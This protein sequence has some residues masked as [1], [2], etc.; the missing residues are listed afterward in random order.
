M[1]GTYQYDVEIKSNVAELLSNMKQ[2]Q[3][4]L[5]TVEGR[6]YTVKLNIDE[7]KLSNVISNLEKMLNS[8][9]K[10]T[11]D[12]KQFEN[13]SK[14]LSTIMSEA[15]SLSKAFG[16]VDDSGTKTLLSSIHNIDKSLSDLS[17]NILNVNKNMSNMGGNTNNAV[18]QIENIT[19][20][21]KEA[22]SAINDIANAKSKI[23]DSNSNNILKA[24]QSYKK[25]AEDYNKVS[26]KSVEL[27]SKLSEK[28]N[29]TKTS[30]KY[31]NER[32]GN[33]LNKFY[34]DIDQDGKNFSKS[35]LNE[36][37]KTIPKTKKDIK[38][39][40][41][42]T[43]DHGTETD[44]KNL[45]KIMGGYFS[46]LDI[47][48]NI[49]EKKISYIKSFTED[50]FKQWEL[51]SAN[52]ESTK[53]KIKPIIKDLLNSLNIDAHDFDIDQLLTNGFLDRI[54]L[55]D[56]GKNPIKNVRKIFDKYNQ[57]I[58]N[59]FGLV[60]VSEINNVDEL[61]KKIGEMI[62]KRNKL[63]DNYVKSLYT[64]DGDHELQKEL[65]LLDEKIVAYSKLQSIVK[66]QRSQESNISSDNKT[67]L[68]AKKELK[69][70]AEGLNYT[71]EQFDKLNGLDEKLFDSIAKGE[72]S[73]REALNKIQV[74][75]QE[76]GN[77]A[78]STSDKISNIFVHFGTD[79]DNSKFEKI[80]NR[81]DGLNKP[82]K[83][84]WGSYLDSEYGWEQ[85]FEDPKKYLTSTYFESNDA[86]EWFAYNEPNKILQSFYKLKEDAHVLVLETVEDLQ[87]LPSRGLH[88]A[89]KAL[90]DWEKIAEQYDAISV[91]ISNSTNEFRQAMYGWDADSL[92][93][94]NPNAIIQVD[95]PD[96][97][98]KEIEIAKQIDLYKQL[99]KEAS[100]PMPIAIQLEDISL[101]NSYKNIVKSTEKELKLGTID[102]NT[103]LE[104]QQEILKGTVFYN[105]K[106]NKLNPTKD[107]F[108]DSSTNT[109]PEIEG[110]EQVEKATEEAVQAKKDFATANEGVQS[111]IDGSENP[112]KLE[113]EL[114]EQ[115]AKSARGAADA[116]KEFV[117]VNKQVKDS[118]NKSNNDLV[119]G[120]SEN[121][122][123]S[124]VK[125]YKKK[126]Y[127]AHDTGNHDNEKKV[128]NK[129][130]LG[131]VLKD[132]QSEIIASIDES[133]SF[134]KEV[135]DFYDSQDNLVKTQMKVG[136]K[137]GNMR[138]YT[139][140]YSMD[141]DDNATAWTSHIETQKFTDQSKEEL[142]V[143]KQITKELEDQEKANQ[144]KF[145]D[146]QKEN[147]DFEEE[148]KETEA[149]KRQKDAYESLMTTI[150]EYGEVYKSLAN[151]QGDS[152]DNLSKMS[153]LE[154]KISELQKKGILSESQIEKSE[155]ALTKIYNQVDKI[156]QKFKETSKIDLTK[157]KDKTNDVN[158][159]KLSKRTVSDNNNKD[160]FEILLSNISKKKEE[161][162]QLINELEK[163]TVTPYDIKNVKNLSAELD[164]LK[165]KAK[166]I[167]IAP[168]N[169]VKFQRVFSELTKL[170]KQYPK[171]TERVR[172]LRAE[173]EKQGKDLA[174]TE[175]LADIDRLRSELISTNAATHTLWATMK[176]KAFFNL[177]QQLGTY[178]SFYDV[179]NGIKRTSEAVIQ[180]NTDI[181]ELAKV[182]EASTSQIYDDFDS[183]ADIAKEIGGTIS[184]TISATADWSKNGYSIPDAKQLAEVSQ[185][186][187]NVGDG[188][189]IDSAN[190]SLISTLKGFQLE[191]DQAEHIVDVFN[192]VSNNEA[193]SS[194]GIGTALQRSAASFNAANTSLEKSVA[195][196]T[197]TRLY[198]LVEYMETYIKNIFNCHRSLYYYVPQYRG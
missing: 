92:V 9:G 6:E 11:G 51:L 28:L 53:N 96:Y 185:L 174:V 67:T 170:E 110:M 33:R 65:N 62:S 168:S 172:E 89:G 127:K 40:M 166:D 188:I 42:K 22:V 35:E 69:E 80:K 45:Q 178:F 18:K 15:Q 85:L 46:Y 184:D 187:K 7:K 50:Y 29:D 131:K 113:A 154:E 8:L 12:F 118:A 142:E 31:K 101:Y 134:V 145:Q 157:F 141:K 176:E 54:S 133:T 155:N 186:Y 122:E 194:S 103:A 164:E 26:E 160:N 93:V 84:F 32:R 76:L 139:T 79:F 148:Q 169:A 120:H 81:I 125:K 20:A 183:Y 180:L 109:K 146:F 61:D 173:F 66:D 163:K 5:D 27:A 34:D 86:K 14:E 41:D 177:A 73:A 38:S 3:D 121:A 100:M 143:Q 111:S 52:L 105:D 98:A 68:D 136:D 19:Y 82:G 107:A 71:N 190:E 181:T 179:I 138:T 63:E 193:I 44:V 47:D 116:K 2:V 36:Y 106:W 24:Y 56:I 167:S 17:Q 37:L 70:Y 72:I 158:I 58:S 10:G 124:G 1:S 77:K 182:S 16:K 189:D 119:S 117:E 129:A 30:Y 171:A 195:L 150:K 75:L 191:A 49:S 156:E 153:S 137:N 147:D 159:D 151:G 126:G 64:G 87:Q 161:L 57:T 95:A 192:E 59:N 88:S 83:G 112:L 197:A 108:P 94:T 128:S 43:F 55:N 114:M 97:K 91:K 23:N 25:E 78:E 21:S 149:I 48:S 198:R 130:E 135:T 4:R 90:I 99:E 175:A 196:V 13:L 60:D 74:E 165:K 123:A 104:K 132:L 102:A 115:I 152:N 39:F 162:L 144:K 140:S